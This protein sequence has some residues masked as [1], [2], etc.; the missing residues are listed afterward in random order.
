MN[1]FSVDFSSFLLPATR[2][3]D[4]GKMYAR[5][6]PRI[7]MGIKGIVLSSEVSRLIMVY[8]GSLATTE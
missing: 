4:K 3:A 1:V 7:N 6:Y 2:N 8:L 5:K